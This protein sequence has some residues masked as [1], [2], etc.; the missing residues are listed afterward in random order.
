[1]LSQNGLWLLSDRDQSPFVGGAKML[2][3]KA[4]G[5]CIWTRHSEEARI[6]FRLSLPIAK[7]IVITVLL[8]MWKIIGLTSKILQQV[9]SACVIETRLKPKHQLVS[10]RNPAGTWEHV[11][12]PWWL[13][14]RSSTFGIIF[15]NKAF[16]KLL[17]GNYRPALLGLSIYRSYLSGLWSHLKNLSVKPRHAEESA[18][19]RA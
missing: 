13:S 11:C 1:M 17:T 6:L 4:N 8:C 16:R 5:V 15:W 19:V 14:S 7:S 12:F 9:R 18:K 3:W 2:A 10:Y